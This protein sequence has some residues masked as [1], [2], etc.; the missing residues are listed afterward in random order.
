MFDQIFKKLFTTQLYLKIK[1]PC[2][3]KLHGLGYF[4][5][6]IESDTKVSFLYHNSRTLI[7]KL[8]LSIC[9]L[10]VLSLH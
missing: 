8:A 9:E 4:N 6:P 2:N 10:Y 7:C 5:P 1:K 3:N